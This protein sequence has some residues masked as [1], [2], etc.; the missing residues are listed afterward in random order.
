MKQGETLALNERIMLSLVSTGVSIQ[1][2][3]WLFGI[4]LLDGKVLFF[5]FS[6]LVMGPSQVLIGLEGRH[7]LLFDLGS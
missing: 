1:F 5:L 6:W 4:C 2:P 3:G 7:C